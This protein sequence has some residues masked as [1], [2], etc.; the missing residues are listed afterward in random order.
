MVNI[1]N[2][3]WLDAEYFCIPVSTM[4]LCSAM[5][6]SCLETFIWVEACF[7]SLLGDSTTDCHLGLFT[8]AEVRSFWT[9]YLMTMNHEHFKILS[10][11][12]EGG[13]F[14]RP[15]SFP[16]I[17]GLICTLLNTWWEHSMNLWIF[18]SVY[19][20]LFWHSALQLLNILFSYTQPISP[21]L[22]QLQTEFLSRLCA[23]EIFTEH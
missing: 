23:P 14:H 7:S 11:P 15:G 19:V 20:S 6:L 3:S 17:P 5:W 18:L 1:V 8:S 10:K 9:L 13:S 4:E 12:D 2:S 22:T 21:H 16:H